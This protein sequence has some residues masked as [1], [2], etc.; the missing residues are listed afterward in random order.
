M[1]N[2]EIELDDI[3]DIKIEETVVTVEV[4]DKAKGH[5]LSAFFNLT[6][7]T[8]GA[9]I[10]AIPIAIKS[11]GLILG[12]ILLFLTVGFAFY[13]FEILL[14][15]CHQSKL[16]NNKELCRSVLGRIPGYL[17]E[18]FIFTFC[19][20]V[21]CVYI[22]LIGESLSLQ[23]K[24]WFGDIWIS[25][26][27]L[28]SIIVLALIMFPL[29]LLRNIR[30]LS[31][32]S[33]ISIICILFVIIVIIIRFVQ[34]AVNK[35]IHVDK[36]VYFNI[37]SLSSISQIFLVIPTFLFSFISQFNLVPIY[38]E[39]KRKKV[40]GMTTVILTSISSCLLLYIIAGVLGYLIFL[41]L[42][43][44]DMKGNILDNFSQSDILV[45]VAKIFICIVIVFSFP[46]LMFASRESFLNIISRPNPHIII[47][48]AITTVLCL[49]SYVVGMF[50]PNVVILIDIVVTISGISANFI[51][52]ML[53]YSVY[54]KQW[55]KRILNIMLIIGIIILGIVSFIQAIINL[56]KLS[57]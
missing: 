31:Y 35:E 57:K 23:F 17:L 22:N 41:D 18:F 30:Y 1:E 49:F 43:L 3:N 40:C 4:K 37:H 16:Y 50:V 29:S 46:I 9:G 45:S 25:N 8:V 13:V 32:T 5:E 10:L 20:G 56:I 54:F 26:K 47:R 36:I 48:I 28:L 53:M 19:F 6:N 12:L 39:L 33:F 14:V 21:C 34:K 38:R 24:A 42:D 44:V 55:W 2:N 51:F 7:T 15:T 27:F 52:P 11:C